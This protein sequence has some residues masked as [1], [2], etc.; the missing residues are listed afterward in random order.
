MI[1]SIKIHCFYGVKGAYSV[2]MLNAS[3]FDH[4]DIA[5]FLKNSF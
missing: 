5:K 1:K 3:V 2:V 4:G